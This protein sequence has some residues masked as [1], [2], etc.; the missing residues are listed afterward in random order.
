LVHRRKLHRP[1]LALPTYDGRGQLH[2][3]RRR[4]CPVKKLGDLVGLHSMQEVH[5]QPLQT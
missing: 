4:R 2:S 5:L 3:L 1:L